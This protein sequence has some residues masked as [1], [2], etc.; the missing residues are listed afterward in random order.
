MAVL[1]TDYKNDIM[2]SEMSGK[3]RYRTTENGDGT[4]S[5]TDETIYSQVGD[6]IGAGDINATN[7]EINSILR[8][9]VSDTA[10]SDTSVLWV[11]PETS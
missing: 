8:I 5:F 3:R 4:V 7:Q 6:T 10:P 11:K 9:V 2:T 1:K